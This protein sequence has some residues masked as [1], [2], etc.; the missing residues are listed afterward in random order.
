MKRVP[1]ELCA[2]HQFPAAYYRFARA[3]PFKNS[4]RAGATC[5][6]HVFGQE[7]PG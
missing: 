3:L 6:A 1:S 2:T 4:Y 5:D 7:G